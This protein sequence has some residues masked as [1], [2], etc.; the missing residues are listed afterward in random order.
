MRFQTE[1]QGSAS[2]VARGHATR[3]RNLAEG[4]A[5]FACGAPGGEMWELGET[6]SLAARLCLEC[7]A[8][9]GAKPTGENSRE[10]QRE[11]SLRPSVWP[12]VR[13]LRV[14]PGDFR[15]VAEA[16]LGRERAA[17]ALRSEEE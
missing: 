4:G 5:C 17:I 9:A 8:R 7:A 2:V 6:N 16:L 14:A 13:D 3:R 10:A 11:M 1:G 15:L 12:V